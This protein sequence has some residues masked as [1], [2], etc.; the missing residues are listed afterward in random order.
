M[1]PDDPNSTPFPHLDLP[2][3]EALAAASA[4]A[5]KVLE[6]VLKKT[7]KVVILTAIGSLEYAV[8]VFVRARSVSEVNNL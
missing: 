1:I 6:T 4:A 2:K 7:P 3:T 5:A 8:F